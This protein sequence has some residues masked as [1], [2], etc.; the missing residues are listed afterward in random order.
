MKPRRI[1]DMEQ[2]SAEWFAARCGKVTASRVADLAAKTKTGYSASR[3]AY[4]SE[5]LV[6]RITGAPV[7]KYVTPAMA[8][9]TAQ[10]KVAREVYEGL[11]G[12]LVETI[13]FVPHP[14]ILNSGASPDGLIG[15]EGLIEIK[16][17]TT[18]T[19]L[20]TV[21]SGEIPDKYIPQIMWQMACTG[22]KWCDFISFDPRVPPKLAM[23]IKHIERN[24]Q[25]I[26]ELETE[27]IKFLKE[28]DDKITA[29][30][31]FGEE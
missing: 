12:N 26:A 28:L 20:E 15:E 23:F 17:P 10:E 19:H 9:G 30:N 25:R 2:G 16:C 31:A 13:G 29:L 14:A 4:M 8:W 1:P 7:D 22:R 11:H 3:A 18:I 5:L 27:V 21:M 6:E 24:D